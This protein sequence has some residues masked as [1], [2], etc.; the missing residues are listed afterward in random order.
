MLTG[1]T[2]DPADTSID[3]DIIREHLAPLSEIDRCIVWGKAC[4]YTP[5]EIV[6]LFLRDMTPK[7]VTR[8]WERLQH[9]YDWIYRLASVRNS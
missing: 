6:E 9:K 7:A 3:N 5:A 1:P 2:A 4:G 8:R